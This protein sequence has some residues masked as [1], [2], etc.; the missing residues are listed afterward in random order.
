MR[1]AIGNFKIQDGLHDEKPFNQLLLR[2]QQ[3]RNYA[4]VSAPSTDNLQG[5]ISGSSNNQQDNKSDESGTLF[6]RICSILKYLFLFQIGFISFATF[7]YFAMKFSSWMYHYCD[8]DDPYS[9]FHNKFLAQSL[10]PIIQLFE[11]I[12]RYLKTMTTI[13][14]IGFEYLTFLNISPYN[15]FYWFKKTPDKTSP[16]F[17]SQKKDLHRKCANR[18]LKLFSENKGVYI[19]LGQHFASLSGF[20]PDEYI[21]VL[22]VMRDQAPTISFDAV[23]KIVYQDFG[24]TIEDMFEYFDPNPIA[25]AS[26][27]QVH[28][29]RTRDGKNVAV[30]IQYHYVRFF[31]EGDMFTRDA[32]TKLSVRL[33]YMQEDPKSIDELLEVNEQFNNEI[34][35]SLN[36]ELDFLHEAKNAKLAAK[37]FSGNRPDVY[38]PEVYDDYTSSR[39]LTMEFIENA[40]NSNDVKRIR[41]MGFDEG[42]IAARIISA[43]AEQLFIHGHLHADTHPSNVFIRQN[44]KDKSSPQ[45]V[46]LDHGLYRTLSDDFRRKY[47]NFWVS[48]VLNDREGMENYCKSLGINDYRLY[49]SMLMMQ[50]L[51]SNGELNAALEKQLTEEDV[52]RFSKQFES[53]VSFSGICFI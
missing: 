33:Y 32:A 6:G 28:R 30:K 44:P 25:S 11:G 36:A 41:E 21:E 19:K 52:E 45:V 43:F 4:T 9:S 31:F 27:A 20:I 47:S 48:I 40:C 10:T 37:N 49:A 18:L 51:D 5:S 50:G 34:K 24:K 42:D 12:D 22:A 15:P 2:Q 17:I 13:L 53:K 26:I 23:K 14:I 7:S 1:R 3:V 38:I 35:D 8:F 46:I 29:A 16:E 39:V